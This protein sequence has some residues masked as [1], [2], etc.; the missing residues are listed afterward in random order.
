[1]NI[2]SPGRIRDSVLSLA[3]KQ[4]PHVRVLTSFPIGGGTLFTIRPSADS[5]VDAITSE[6]SRQWPLCEVS[7]RSSDLDGA[8]DVAILVPS[9][10]TAW[11][12]AKTAAGKWWLS[13]LIQVCK[14]GTL[15]A[16]CVVF[17]VAFVER[18]KRAEVD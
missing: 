15:A 10:S 5:D 4:D 14:K 9:R 18:L 7:Q 11:S 6:V 2:A 13:V 12:L 8:T 17:V 3:K 1:M 16:A